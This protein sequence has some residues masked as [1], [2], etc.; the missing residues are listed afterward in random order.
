M[1]L[2]NQQEFFSIYEVV[3]LL[4]L[5]ILAVGLLF[6]LL[7]FYKRILRISEDRRKQEYQ[8]KIES[9]L[10]SFLF[11]EMSI[12]EIQEDQDF[13][14]MFQ[15]GLFQKVSIKAIISLHHSY[16]G[17]YSRKLEQFYE[18]AGFANY[19]VKRLNSR[20]WPHVV[21]AIRDLSTM[22]H[23]KSYPRIASHIV[24]KHPYVKTEVLIAM[25]KMKGISEIYKFRDSAMFLNDWV[26][27]CI[28]FTVKK[29]N[30]P[31]PPDLVDLLK[32]RNRSIVMLTVRLIDYYK[33]AE[34]YTVLSSFYQQTVDIKLKKEMALVLRK[35]ESI[36]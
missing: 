20:K 1:H 35:T 14:K 26:Q 16:S 12:K 24:H 6:F 21:E 29:H 34:H 36:Y 2:T 11:G 7:T 10:F 4:I 5:L 15:S 19:S 22:N 31:A 8:E 9:L 33:S 18:E 17:A 30:I 13:Q 28:L 25:I 32:S 23:L 3:L 27:S